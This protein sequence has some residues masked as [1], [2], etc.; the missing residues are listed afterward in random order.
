[1]KF[2]V[3]I[4]CYNAASWI[5]SCLQSVAVQTHPAHEVIV[6]DDGSTDDSLARIESAGVRVHILHT[7]RANAAGARNAGIA[8][9]T[10]DWIALLDADD[11]WYPNHLERAASLLEGSH[12]VAFMA[13]HDWIGLTGE[14]LPMAPGFKC[15]ITEPAPGLSPARFVQILAH[16]LHFGHSTV[17]YRRQRLLEA[18]CFDV[19]QYRRHDIDLW[20]RAI[21][22]HTWTYDPVKSAGYRNDTPGGISMNLVN[23]EYYYLRALLKNSEAY[24][25]PEM[26]GLI[27]TSARR[28]MG[29]AFVNGSEREF[30]Q[31]KE[32]SWPYLKPGFRTF[33]RLAAICPPPFRWMLRLRRRILWGAAAP[34]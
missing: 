32:L 18:G 17:V 20:L 1:M 16:G 12:D 27:S 23:C 11:V 21:H 10:G 14:V 2:S 25:L 26:R 7:A 22:G 3:I 31:A 29:L 19:E 5:G 8:A 30:R 9:A 34:S 6:I 28:G 24:R 33:Y 13:A 15:D 4:P